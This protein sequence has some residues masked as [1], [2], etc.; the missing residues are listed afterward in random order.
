MTV[1]APTGQEA[2]KGRGGRP[3]S[4]V[5]CLGTMQ[6]ST[7]SVRVS[8]ASAQVSMPGPATTVQ[9]STSGP[10]TMEASTS[11]QWP[12]RARRWV[13]ARASVPS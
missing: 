10:M 12:Q 11:V 13:Q 1:L 3:P 5:L 9:A 7:M 8:E 2:R 4:E 6:E